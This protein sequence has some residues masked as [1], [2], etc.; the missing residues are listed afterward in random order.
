VDPLVSGENIFITGYGGAQ[1][2]RLAGDT[3]S[4]VYETRSLRSSFSNPVLLGGYLYGSDRGT[5]R[6]IEWATGADKW[7]RPNALLRPPGQER[8]GERRHPLG[9]GALI[10]AGKH[11]IVLDEGGNLRLVAATP[12]AYRE[13]AHAR[14]LEGPCWTA[15]VLA[16]GLLFCRNN[17][18]D[19][20]C[21]DLRAVK[22]GM[23]RRAAQ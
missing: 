16:N 17:A 2:L 8:E 6:C 23:A 3:V 1:Q 22:Q 9:E 21:V 12:A 18:G 20:V 7:S 4:V 5:L 15:P 13:L 10:A 11:L 14:V 19:L